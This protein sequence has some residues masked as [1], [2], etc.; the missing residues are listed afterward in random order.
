MSPIFTFENSK[1]SLD[2]YPLTF[3]LTSN[4]L[5]LTSLLQMQPFYLFGEQRLHF[6]FIKIT[7]SIGICITK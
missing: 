7:V 6:L 3:K 4:D 5:L 1:N 2:I